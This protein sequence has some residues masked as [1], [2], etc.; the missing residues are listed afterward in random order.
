M[1]G[2]IEERLAAVERALTDGDHDCAALAEGAATADRVA[3]LEA[4]LEET[5]DRVAELEAATQA[6]RGYVGNVRS[7]N[8]EVEQR[9]DEALETAQAARRAAAGTAPSPD[10]TADPDTPSADRS[11][12]KSDGYADHGYGGYCEHCERPLDDGTADHESSR[13]SGPDQPRIRDLGDGPAT[14]VRPDERLENAPD[15]E[16]DGGGFGTRDTTPEP[17]LVARVRDLL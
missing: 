11:E 7:V 13:S 15:A 4:G 16:T 2:T 12:S 6:L 3:E 10:A 1:D 14:R 17:G 5:T 9:A 8:D